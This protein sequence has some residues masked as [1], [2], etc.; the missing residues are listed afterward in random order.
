MEGFAST[1]SLIP[2][3]VWDTTDIPD[4][5]MLIGRPTGSALPLV[6]AHAEY[7]KLLRSEHDAAIF[8]LITAVRKRY[9]DDCVTT[10][11]QVGTFKQSRG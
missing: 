9:I 6:W 4:E 7:I 3:Q 11:L 5:H 10:D 1:C 2:E 8:D